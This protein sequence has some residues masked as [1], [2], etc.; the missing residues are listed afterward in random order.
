M[1]LICLVII[2]MCVCANVRRKKTE[3]MEEERQMKTLLS[4]DVT[5]NKETTTV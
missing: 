3:E 1:S 4:L 2:L 5:N